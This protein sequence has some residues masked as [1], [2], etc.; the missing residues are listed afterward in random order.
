MLKHPKPKKHSNMQLSLDLDDQ[1]M[2]MVNQNLPSNFPIF[3]SY[4][5]SIYSSSSSIPKPS[6]V[7]FLK[8]N[9]IST[10]SGITGT[11]RLHNRREGNV[12][13]KYQMIIC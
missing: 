3:I 13:V 4:L 12:K 6:N 9:P 10:T 8:S 2:N 5:A 7:G 1:L 11:S